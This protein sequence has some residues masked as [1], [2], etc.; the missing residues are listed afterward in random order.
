VR[1]RSPSRKSLITRKT[2]EIGEGSMGKDRLL[3]NL[4]P[5]RRG[6]AGNFPIMKETIQGSQAQNPPQTPPPKKKHPRTPHPTTPKRPPPKPPPN[7]QKK[8][9]KNPP[10]PPPHQTKPKPKNQNYAGAPPRARK[11]TPKWPCPP[12]RVSGFHLTL[13][14]DLVVKRLRG[15][16]VKVRGIPPCCG[17]G[18]SCLMGWGILKDSRVKSK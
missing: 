17:G 14:A 6:G 1:K 9:K 10:P 16:G 2:W 7:P 3:V 8:K 5:R 18:K 15:W 4:N 12:A 13:P 11:R